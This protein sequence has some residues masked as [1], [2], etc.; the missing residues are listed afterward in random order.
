MDVVQAYSGHERNVLEEVTRARSRSLDAGSVKDR[1][2]S[3]NT[4]SQRLKSL[5][6]VAEAYPD[7]KAD[8]TYLELQKQLVEVED[9]IQMARRYYNGTVRNYDIRVESFPSNIAARIFGFRRADYFE[10]ETATERETPD[11]EM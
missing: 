10:I 9:Q 5:F 11:V 7:L 6:A 3:E 4:L 1:E 8:Q 2:A